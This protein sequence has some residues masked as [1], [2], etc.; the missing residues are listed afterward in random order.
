M[1]LRRPKPQKLLNGGDEKSAAILTENAEQEVGHVGAA[2]RWFRCAACRTARFERRS[3]ELQA[4]F[5]VRVTGM[6]PSKS[7]T[8]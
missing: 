7:F 2:V 4:G 5:S 1:K 3:T 8:T 6:N